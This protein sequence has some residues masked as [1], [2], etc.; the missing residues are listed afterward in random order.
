MAHQRIVAVGREPAGDDVE[1]LGN[2]AILPGLVNAHTHLEFSDLTG[3]IGEPRMGIVAWIRRVMDYRRQ[4][5]PASGSSVEM[6]LQQSVRLGTTTLAEIAQPEW[7]PQAFDKPECDATVLMELIAPRIERVPA[8]IE[9]AR[10]HLAAA[11]GQTLWRP[12]LSPHA[13]Y[14]AHPELLRQV[15]AMSATHHVPVAFHL[16]ESR[17]EMELL[18]T[19]SGP[20][21]EL[22]VSLG[23]WDPTAFWPGMTPL[24]YLHI[25]ARAERALIIHG[26]YL[27]DD[28]VAMLAE[29][30]DRMTVVY[31]PP[32][33]RM[34]RPQAL[35]A[36][37]D[38]GGRR[39]GGLGHG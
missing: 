23:A 26:N 19:G 5:K 17:E 27:G 1:D 16:A 25:L 20:F 18:E 13:P 32:H 22:L 10:Q 9:L 12:G 33:A 15:V 38:V 6:G 30:R 2:V 36:G 21:E 4:S 11:A 35:S 14:S 39:H 28:E 29:N 8:A 3:P 37:E 7:P 31:C 34:V 24:D